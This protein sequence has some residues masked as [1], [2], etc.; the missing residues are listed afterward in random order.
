M[1]RAS[2]NIIVQTRFPLTRVPLPLRV[3]PITYNTNQ[4]RVTDYLQ[5]GNLFEYG[6]T[7]EKL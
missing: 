3:L 7:T 5:L 1:F 6:T 4:L 2:L